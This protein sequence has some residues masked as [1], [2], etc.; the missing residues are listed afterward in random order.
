MPVVI[1]L[2]CLAA[3]TIGAVVGV[4]GGIII[5]PVVDALGVFTASE[6]SFLSGCTVLIMSVSSLIRS[7]GNG[8]TLD[9]RISTPVAIGAATGGLLGKWIFGLVKTAVGNETLVGGVQS[10][11]LCA[12]TALVLAYMLFKAHVPALHM[13]SAA[14]SAL[15]GLVLGMIS[16]FLGIGGGPL[17]VALLLILFSM[18]SKQAAKNS[19]YIILFSQTA[20]LLFSL[21]TRTIPDFQWPQLLLMMCG[22]VGGALIGAYVSKRINTQGVDRLMI[23]LNIFVILLTIRNAWAAFGS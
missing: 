21:A 10:V 3:S 15:A 13:D 17:N 7:T 14:V 19:I 4:G 2:V 23:L 12:V 8:V 9:T 22:G 18:D 6:L 11:C 1:F 20:N 5:K 16:S